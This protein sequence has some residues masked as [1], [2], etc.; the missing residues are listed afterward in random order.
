MMKIVALLF[1]RQGLFFSYRMVVLSRFQ[2][3]FQLIN[4]EIHKL[5]PCGGIGE[6]ASCLLSLS[7]PILT[8]G[9]AVSFCSS[10]FTVLPLSLA[11]IANIL[12]VPLLT[13][14]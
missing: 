8:K 12:T 6:Q 5:P 2:G 9:F 3:C 14:S 13:V 7:H 10:Q 11:M 1:W 4:L